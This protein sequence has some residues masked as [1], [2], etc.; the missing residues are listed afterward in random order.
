MNYYLNSYFSSHTKSVSIPDVEVVEETEVE[1]DVVEV[2]EVVGASVV[3]VRPETCIQLFII[4]YHVTLDIC[5]RS[6]M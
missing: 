3:V 4:H 6:L 2:E 1:V 5:I